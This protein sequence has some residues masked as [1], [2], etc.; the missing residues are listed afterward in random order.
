MKK[1]PRLPAQIF[2]IEAYEVCSWSPGAEGENKPPTQVHLLLHLRGL[3]PLV[4]RLKSFQAVTNMIDALKHHRDF[5]WNPHRTLESK[6]IVTRADGSPIDPTA[7]YFLL[8]LDSDLAARKAA[9]HYADL[10]QEDNP[11]LA[12]DL[13]SRVQSYDAGKHVLQI[14]D[15]VRHKHLTM[16]QRGMLNTQTSKA[17]IVDK[18][19]GKFLLRFEGGD[20]ELWC[21]EHEF[22]LREDR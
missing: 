13:R 22:K 20:A 14:G 2:Q 17:V 16:G 10:I 7:D 4:M 3:A 1:T 6:Y 11:L 8:R 21:E 19:D 5:V 18:K 15:K 9:L 12:D